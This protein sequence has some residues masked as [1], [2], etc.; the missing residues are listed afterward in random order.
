MMMVAWL[1]QASHVFGHHQGVNQRDSVIV[2]VVFGLENA[3]LKAAS[4]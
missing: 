1:P 2:R 3:G 4:Q